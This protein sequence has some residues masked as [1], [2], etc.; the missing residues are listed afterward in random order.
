MLSGVKMCCNGVIWNSVIFGW[1]IMMIV[2][3]IFLFRKFRNDKEY[4]VYEIYI[5]KC[6]GCEV[7]KECCYREFDDFYK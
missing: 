1:F 4:I 3:L 5:M 2:L 7:I 6:N